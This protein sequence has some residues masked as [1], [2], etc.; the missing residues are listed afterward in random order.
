MVVGLINYLDTRRP[1]YL[2]LGAMAMGLG[3]VAGPDTSTL[4]LIFGLFALLLFLALATRA[5][6]RI[7]VEAGAAHQAVR[8]GAWRLA[9]MVP[10]RLLGVCH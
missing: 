10:K 8:K 7:G 4:L 2:Y 1:A 3:L 9:Q 5:A 6:N